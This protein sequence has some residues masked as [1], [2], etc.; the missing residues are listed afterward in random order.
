MDEYGAA[1]KLFKLCE[2]GIQHD[3]IYSF[4]VHKNQ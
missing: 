4:S 1:S 3:S 2:Q